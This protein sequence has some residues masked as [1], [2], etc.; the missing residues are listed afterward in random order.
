LIDSKIKKI[1]FI[2]GTR[3][4]YGKLKPLIASLK[5]IKKIKIKIFITGMH[6]LKKYGYTYK[7]IKDVK[8]DDRYIFVNQSEFDSQELVL[9]K[10][11][12]G[13]SDFV[14]EEKPDLIVV[15]G[16]RIEPLAAALVGSF[17][18]ILVAHVEGGEVSGTIDEQIRHA[19]S[20]LAHAHF[21]TNITAQKRLL[22]MGENPKSIFVIG[23]PDIDSMKSRNLPS[24]IK[25]K[26]KYDIDFSDYCISILH[27]VTSELSKFKKSS[28]IYF[29]S[30]IRS[31]KNYIVLYPNNDPGSKFIFDTIREL[32]LQ[33]NNRFRILPSMRFEYYLTI[34]KHAKLII[35]NS[36]SG[37]YESTFFGVPSINIGTRQRNRST[38]KSIVNIDFDK[39]EILNAIQTFYDVTF[40]KSTE[41]GTGNSHK[42][43]NKHI[44]SKSFWNTPS[45]KYFFQ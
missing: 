20:K 6:T 9:S 4:D 18:N 25:S 32:K 37:I 28:E 44:K 17:N 34:L 43:F 5:N 21:V 2:T 15:H 1:I 29:D 19:I 39:T 8:A 35:G 13:F 11:I 38:S 36:S 23:S 10:T 45:Q 27:P 24:L 7:I 40:K 42:L 41:F 3:A 30:L 31:G 26:K 22:S 33:Q 16:D 12:L 14:K